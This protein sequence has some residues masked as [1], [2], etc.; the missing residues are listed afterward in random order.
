MHSLVLTFGQVERHG[1][2][3]YYGVI[4][5]LKTKDA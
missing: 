4:F 1:L 3:Q 2:S 5:E